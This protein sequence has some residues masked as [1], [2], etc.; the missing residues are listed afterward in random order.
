MAAISVKFRREVDDADCTERAFLYAYATPSAN[1]LHNNRFFLSLHELDCVSSVQDLGTKSVAWDTAVI[2]L[3]SL[4]LKHSYSRHCRSPQAG[5]P[6][7][8]LIF[9][10]ACDA[11]E[12]KKTRNTVVQSG[13]RR[14]TRL[15]PSLRPLLRPS[16][17]LP[18][19]N[20]LASRTAAYVAKCEFLLSLF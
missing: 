17:L 8:E 19:S 13:P 10:K 15:L 12:T 6:G 20:F 9:K 2:G 3:A 11:S 14:P 18:H 16:L 7:I 5:K 4:F 1:V